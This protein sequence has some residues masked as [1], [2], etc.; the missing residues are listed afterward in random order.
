MYVV[1]GLPPALH[2]WAV[3]Q[4][5]ADLLDQVEVIAAPSTA[6][7]GALYSDGLIEIL[8]SAITGFAIRR[9]T[10]GPPHPVTPTSISLLYVPSPDQE[11]LVRAL[12]FA[13]MPMPLPTLAVRGIDGRQLRHSFSAV[14]DALQ[15]ATRSTGQNKKT[16]DHIIERINRLSDREALLLPPR[17]FHTAQGNMEGVF[18]DLRA[19]RRSWS[20]AF[21]GLT[22]EEFTKD[23]L[24]R[25]PANKTRRAFVDARSVV[26]FTADQRA[27][28]GTAREIGEASTRDGRMSVLRSLYRFGASLPN[29]FHHDA[30]LAD[31]SVFRNFQFDCDADGPVYVRATHVNVYPNDYVR[32]DQKLKI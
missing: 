27:F 11:R 4:L 10:R 13:V 26:F 23:R 14:R 24:P 20:D 17:N 7:D 12:D 18:I 30:Q 9:R 29:G 32:A 16:L 8:L 6:R 21:A 28:H 25:L 2:N 22:I 15:N 1:A 19:G 3:K 31:G 5:R